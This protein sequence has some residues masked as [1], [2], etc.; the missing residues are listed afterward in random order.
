MAREMR[1]FPRALI[2]VALL[3]LTATGPTGRAFARGVAPARLGALSWRMIGPFR[4]G[5]VSA[6]AG[7]P[8]APFT[9]YM[10]PDN[11]GVWKTTDAGRTWLPIFDAQATQSIGALAV[12]PSDPRVVYAGS[13]E[14]LQRPDLSV[15]DGLYASHDAGATWTHLGLRSG[16]QIAKIAIDPHDA[17]RLY[18]A[19]LGHP[20]GPNA[21]RGIYRSTDGGL[22][23]AHVLERGPDTGAFDVAIAPGN[24]RTLYATLWSA[25]WP[26]WMAFGSLER[27]AAGDGIYKSSD[28]GDT[29][30][31]LTRDLPGAREH[32]GRCEIAVA[33]NDPAR[34]YAAIDA[35]GGGGIYRSDDAGATW[36][37]TNSEDRITERGDDLANLAVDPHDRDTLWFTNTTTYRSSDAGRTFTAMKGAPGG[38]DYHALWIAPG[39]SNVIA[40]GSD[41]GAT[42]SLNGGATWSSW[43]NQPTAQMFH[44]TTDDRFPYWV[45]GGQQESG[46]VG[47]ASRGNDGAI[48]FRDWHPVGAEE[49]GYV[50]PDPLHPTIVY[51]GKGQEFDFVTGQVRDVSPV[52]E[53]GTTYRFDRTAPL[54]FSHADPHLLYLGANVVFATRDGGSTWKTISPDLTR[55]AP[56]LPRTLTAFAADDAAHGLHRGVIYALA[57]SYRDAA[58]LWAG[59]DDGYV[60]RTHDGGAT[61]Q[62]VTPPAVGAW[63][64]V[65]QIDAA[66]Y[67]DE[68][69]Y[70]SVS[71]FLLD[72]LAPYVYRTH[73]GGRT[74]KRITDGLPA[75]APVNAVRADPVRR[76]LLYAATERGVGLSFDD[77]E[78]W[79]PLQANL[80]A[81]SVRDL[82]VHGNDLAIATHGRSFY[83]MDDI[84]ALRELDPSPHGPAP[85]RLYA[86]A[87]AV[88]VRR[89]TNSDTP[90]PPEE[91]VGQNPPDG[92]IFDYELTRAAR[93][94]ALEIAT[95]DGHVVRRCDSSDAAPV[96]A[97]LEIPTYWIAPFERLGITSG[98]HRF[99]WDLHAAPPLA[100]EYGYPIAAIDHATPRE[101]LGPLAPPGT[102]RATLVVDGERRSA[103]FEVLPD[104]RVSASAADYERQ[105]AVATRLAEL[106]DACTRAATRALASRRTDGIALATELSDASAP[107]EPLLGSIESADAAPTA[108][109]LAAASDAS[110]VAERALAHWRTWRDLHARAAGQR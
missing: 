22:T 24:G 97:P 98:M 13:G 72:D 14:G 83:I 37:H 31:Q 43:Y 100:P 99:V 71:R 53:R 105:Y 75:D 41:Q 39:D 101:P 66:R 74:W 108:A 42:I 91:S 11:G 40:L 63:S 78:T 34:L 62:N 5:R 85:E 93:D 103:P 15:G 67:D 52:F 81:T 57:P 96:D 88:R 59:T 17:R 36:Q 21:E 109:Q 69:A 27:P 32:I 18:V 10:A 4:G 1:I 16:E 30:S 23:F 49:Y 35:H 47:I 77:G 56:A 95:P 92:A 90:L 64:K 9:F 82:V 38:D 86:P 60:W 89:D 33:P 28:G 76:G 3:A 61:W 44:V 29:W 54:I 26:P 107:L 58:V 84:A 80:P 48:T 8:G 73:D 46:S 51:G 7:V 104:P 25:R 55:P 2:V 87:N 102:Y 6:I 12:A 19:V 68:T 79:Q 110:H 50:A 94:V 45:Y 106:M 70:V 20:Y 65:T